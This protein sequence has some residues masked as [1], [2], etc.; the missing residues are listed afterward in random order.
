MK[1]EPKVFI[2]H[3]LESIALIE[4]YAEQLSKKEFFEKVPIQD[5]VIRRLEIIGEAT[6]NVPSEWRDKYQDIPW[7]QVAG[8]RDI[9]IHEYFGVD[10]DLTWRV[11]KEDLPELKQKLGEI[12]EE[13]NRK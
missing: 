13:I 9:L 10:L 4:T 3:I 7:R 6:K 12:I 1:K 2:E 5:A 8:M 11:I